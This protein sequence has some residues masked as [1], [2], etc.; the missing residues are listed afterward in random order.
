MG[1]R[2]TLL[3]AWPGPGVFFKG[4]PSEG[5]EDSLGPGPRT[6]DP[7]PSRH[8]PGSLARRPPT[9]PCPGLRRAGPGRGMRP[10]Q[11][12]GPCAE[13]GTAAGAAS[14]P[15]ARSCGGHWAPSPTPGRSPGLQT[16]G[17]GRG[18]PGARPRKPGQLPA[19]E[20]RLR[21]QPP[22]PGTAA[23]GRCTQWGRCPGLRPPDR[24]ALCAGDRGPIQL[25]LRAPAVGGP[26]RTP[27]PHS[28]PEA[29][30]WATLA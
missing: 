29:A 4:G 30:T 2:R 11:L 25:G 26:A 15:P 20:P 1:D 27:V 14:T 9:K 3:D 24:H 19:E 28:G 6:K 12:R 16:L 5:Q 7:A 18:P 13:P 8:L 17:P 10:Q 21:P 22:G 23:G